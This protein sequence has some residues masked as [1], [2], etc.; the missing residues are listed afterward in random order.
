MFL[1]SLS[2]KLG[3]YRYLPLFFVLGASIEWFMINVRVG[4]ETFY[5][6]A[7]RLESKG[8]IAAAAEEGESEIEEVKSESHDS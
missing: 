5:D 8:K 6:T 1:P 4:K 2:K 7:L 3:P